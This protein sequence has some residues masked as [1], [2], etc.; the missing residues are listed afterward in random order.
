MMIMLEMMCHAI[1]TQL[2][3]INDD[4]DELITVS[5]YDTEVTPK[6]H[7][8]RGLMGWLAGFIY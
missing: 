8:I 6:K 1:V 3:I 2:S 5:N 7:S 4:S